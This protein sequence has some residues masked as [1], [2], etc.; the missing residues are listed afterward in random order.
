M[1]GQ[2][3]GRLN[4]LLT[5]TTQ[6]ANLQSDV[7]T[8]QGRMNALAVAASIGQ[9]DRIRCYDTL[10]E[11]DTKNGSVKLMSG[12]IIEL[13]ELVGIDVRPGEV[14][15]LRDMMENIMSALRR[16]MAIASYHLSFLSLMPC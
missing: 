12:Q 10:A 7:H 16:S 1:D 3:R 5:L 4:G 14:T 15:S 2:R 13:I 8:L 6:V 9:S 11:L